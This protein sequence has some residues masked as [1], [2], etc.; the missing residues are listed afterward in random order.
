MILVIRIVSALALIIAL[1]FG[2]PFTAAD[3][4]AGAVANWPS[5]RGSNA[6]GIADGYPLPSHWD[7]ASSKNI[8]WKTTIPGLG[9]SSPVIWGDRIYLS[10]AIGGDRDGLKIGLYGDI[11]SVQDD[12]T[13]RWI[14][15]CL[16]KNSGKILWEKTLLTAVPKIKRHP[17]STHANSTLATDGKHVVAFFGSEGLFCLDT[18]GKQLWKADFGI[19][20]SSFFMAPTAQWEFASSPVIFQDKVLIQC[21]VLKGSFIAALNIVDGKELWRTSRD[22]VPTWSTPSILPA[23]NGSGASLILNGYKH[24]GG[25]DVKTGKEIWR[26]AGG[27]DIP[28]PTPVVWKDLIFITNAHGK[29]SPVY[30]IRSGATGDISLK[31]N[32]TSNRFVAWSLPRDG[33]YMSTPLV[34]GDKLYNCRWN[35]VLSCYQADSGERLYQERLGGG[36]SGFTASPVG[37]DGKIFIPSEEGDVYVVKAGPTFELIGKNP[38]DEVCMASPAISEGKLYFRT[39]THLIAVAAQE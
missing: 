7:A 20:D 2:W 10:T 36:T 33:S 18:E 1:G 22:D 9:L 23:S 25:Y 35:G 31:D 29:L 3:C 32:E 15:Y 16:D 17:K 28:V 12:T 6:S 8:R 11:A 34:Y 37:G 39:K 4:E 19:L 14:V 27:G 13:H 21:D 5:F 26:L 30:A 24:I 38:L